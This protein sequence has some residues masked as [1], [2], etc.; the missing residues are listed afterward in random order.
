MVGGES[1]LAEK[2]RPFLEAPETLKVISRLV[3]TR[4]SVIVCKLGTEAVHLHPLAWPIQDWEPARPFFGRKKKGGGV[5]GREKKEKEK[6]SVGIMVMMRFR[7]CKRQ[8]H[9]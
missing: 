7:D 3:S 2:T 4:V 1:S 9:F 8:T 5:V 6:T